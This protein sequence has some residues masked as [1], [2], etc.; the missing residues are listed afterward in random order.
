MTFRQESWWTLLF[1]LINSVACAMCEAVLWPSRRSQPSSLP[2]PPNS[3]V[4][5]TPHL[6]ALT[7]IQKS[8]SILLMKQ[9]VGAKGLLSLNCMNA[10]WHNTYEE[11]PSDM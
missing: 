4:C 1:L 7:K 9:Q 3:A 6:S 10:K 2:S 5:G 8:D 11:E